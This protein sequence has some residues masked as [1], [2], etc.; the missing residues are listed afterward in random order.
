MYEQI[1]NKL[2]CGF[3]LLGDRQV[4]N[5]VDPVRVY[6]VLPDPAAIASARRARQVLLIIVLGAALLAITGGAVWPQ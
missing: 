6:R 4:K 3:Q 2:V 5:I 1:K